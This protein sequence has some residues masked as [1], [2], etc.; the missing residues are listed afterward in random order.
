MAEAF[1]IHE[2][3]AVHLPADNVDTDQIIPSREMKSVSRTGLADGLFA[4]W[5]Y[6]EPG[7]RTPRADFILNRDEAR[8]ASI[9]ISGR[10]FGCGSSREHA[11]W[12][13]AEYGF[14]VIIAQSFGAI[15]RGNCLRNGVLPIVL[16][17]APLRPWA[18]VERL[19]IDLP[20]QTVTREDDPGWVGTFAIDPFPKTL[21]RE[22]LDP[23]AHTLKFRDAIETHLDADMAARPWVYSAA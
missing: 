23:I 10:N 9:L 6:E 18:P 8:G 5:R 16:D 14:R 7:G 1:E 20:A 4:G 19:T 13:L 2:G 22:G 21:L 15:F 12:A 3:L 11:V 17:E